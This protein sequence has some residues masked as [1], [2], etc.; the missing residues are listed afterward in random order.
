[1]VCAYGVCA[2]NFYVRAKLQVLFGQGFGQHNDKSFRAGE[3]L[4][5]ESGPV[6]SDAQ[7]RE[8]MTQI[9]DMWAN[10]GGSAKNA[11]G[12]LWSLS[13]LSAFIQDTFMQEKV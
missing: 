8:V 11:D 10:Q 13:F 6:R 9:L 3:R 4:C 2:D 12:H 7:F 5:P 1:V